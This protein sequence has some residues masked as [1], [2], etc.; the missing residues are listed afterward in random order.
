MRQVASARKE[1]TIRA[2]ANLERALENGVDTLRL[3]AD[4]KDGGVD[5]LELVS[6][7]AVHALERCEAHP[8][9]DGARA[10]YRAARRVELAARACQPEYRACAENSPSSEKKTASLEKRGKTR[11]VSPLSRDARDD[12]V[13]L[14]HSHSRSGSGSG[15]AERSSFGGKKTRGGALY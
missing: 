15:S 14:S 13:A 8:H 12:R 1:A 4:P 10:F 2:R 11:T 3:G 5:P 9:G 6:L 7:I